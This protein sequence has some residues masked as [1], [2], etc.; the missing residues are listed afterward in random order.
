MKRYQQDNKEKLKQYKK[1][2]KEM[3]KIHQKKYHD[4]HKD[5]IK[6]YQCMYRAKNIE[7]RIECLRL[8]QILEKQKP[9]FLEKENSDTLGNQS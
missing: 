7:K 4:S 9:D 6:A 1:D 2:N 8:N 5:E 3:I